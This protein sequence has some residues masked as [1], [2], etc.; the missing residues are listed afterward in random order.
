MDEIN[1]NNNYINSQLNF[2][3][4]E[5]LRLFNDKYSEYEY[6]TKNMNKNNNEEEENLSFEGIIS[7]EPLSN[8]YEIIPY[9][10]LNLF[11]N[12]L[13][14][15]IISKFLIGKTTKYQ[16][17][18][19]ILI[20]PRIVL[21]VAHNLLIDGIKADKI[22]FCPISNGTFSLCENIISDK[23]YIPNEFIYYGN[24]NEKKEQLL[25]D[26]G[27]IF[28][29]W[30]VGEYIINS[31][32]AYFKDYNGY[33][34]ENTC[35]Y[36]FFLNEL[37]NNENYNDEKISK[38]ILIILGYTSYDEAIKFS[39]YNIIKSNKNCFIRTKSLNSSHKM[40]HQSNKQLYNNINNSSINQQIQGKIFAELVDEIN[41]SNNKFLNLNIEK[42]IEENN[43][44]SS[45]LN[46]ETKKEN[47][48]DTYIITKL[49]RKSFQKNKNY[50]LYCETNY[51]I[52]PYI[53][54]DEIEKIK[55]IYN[56]N[57]DKDLV[58]TH[59]KG[60]ILSIISEKTNNIIKYRIT[61]YKGQ[62]GSPIFLK[63]IKTNQLRFLGLHSRRGPVIDIM[64]IIKLY[65]NKNN[66]NRSFSYNSSI[67]SKKNKSLENL[68]DPVNGVCDFN[69]ALGFNKETILKISQI[70][71]SQ[72]VPMIL[73]DYNIDSIYFNI[74]LLIYKSNKV[75]NGIFKR[76]LMLENI[77]IISSKIIGIDVD[78]IL[79]KDNTEM[80]Y[81]YAFDKE[82][83]LEEVFD[84]NNHVIENLVYYQKFFEIGINTKVYCE[85]LSNEII[86]KFLRNNFIKIN[87]LKDNLSQYSI[88]LFKS[89]FEHLSTIDCKLQIYGEIF[90]KIRTNIL[91]K[92]ENCI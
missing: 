81:N 87:Q 28:F 75:I 90:K 83:T 49:F 18:V 21:T 84:Y 17:G 11:P 69:I 34:K 20:G 54:F 56:D 3:T 23:F 89:I 60:K 8:Q 45:S 76:N 59:S 73:S 36:Q 44:N 46:E 57:P 26:W 71:Y 33:L 48:Y 16:Y 29:N 35:L 40:I 72:T 41:Q 37:S 66:L 70:C 2:S 51:N 65:C 91:N 7:K 39:E 67:L 52:I 15:R 79:L 64:K 38:N 86:S 43:I 25:Y 85:N 13:V 68:I 92:I 55:D 50:N 12:C 58:M 47:E 27:L 74:S 31:V 1:T 78:Y 30:D 82:K 14:G 32:N 6:L 10:L 77:F 42:E 24:I 5:Q 62:S 22:F 88:P 61:T 63:N 9:S 4:S 53:L 19:A 80:I